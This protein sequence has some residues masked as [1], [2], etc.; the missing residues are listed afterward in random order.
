MKGEM[1]HEYRTKY[2][3]KV[4]YL[5]AELFIWEVNIKTDLGE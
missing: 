3:M 1:G 5:G 2:A 4:G